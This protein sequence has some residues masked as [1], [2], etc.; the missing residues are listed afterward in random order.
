MNTSELIDMIFNDS[1]TNSSS[2]T[3]EKDKYWAYLFLTTTLLSVILN[4][5]TL[6]MFSTQGKL[7]TGFNVYLMNLSLANFVYSASEGPLD[8][9]NSFYPDWWLGYQWCTIYLYAS[10]VLSLVQVFTHPL[11]ALNRL[12]ATA[13]PL[14]YRKYHSTRIAVIF[15]TGTWIF[16]HFIALPIVILDDLYYRKSIKVEGCTINTDESIQKTQML[17]LQVVSVASEVV[18]LA[19][20]PIIWK[21][22]RD[23]EKIRQINRL[24]NRSATTVPVSGSSPES[25]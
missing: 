16:G 5:L 8:F 7:C 6:V 21:K 17:I 18:V 22:R 13:L 25:N 23:R 9:I 20:L 3:P 24:A 19:L 11:I 15:C 14:L 4:G 10:W 12:W 1:T 2:E